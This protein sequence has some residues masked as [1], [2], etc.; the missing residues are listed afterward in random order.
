[1]A[2]YILGSIFRRNARSGVSRFMPIDKTDR[3]ENILNNKKLIAI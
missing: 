1:M 3:T 2:E